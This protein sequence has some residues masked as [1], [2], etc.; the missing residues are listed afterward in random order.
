MIPRVASPV[1]AIIG[2]EN[3]LNYIEQDISDYFV[4]LKKV[5]RGTPAWLFIPNYNT[6]YFDSQ[7]DLYEYVQNENY[8]TSFEF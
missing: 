3:E 1:I 8:L 2:K 4:A 5:Q 7:E 6:K